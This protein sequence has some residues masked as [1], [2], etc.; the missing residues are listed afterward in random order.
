MIPRS[1]SKHATSTSDSPLSRLKE[2]RQ[3]TEARIGNK[4]GTG[5]TGLGSRSNFSL[6]ERLR[7]TTFDRETPIFQHRRTAASQLREI[8]QIARDGSIITKASQN[9][10]LRQEKIFTK[11]PSV[12]S[13]LSVLNAAKVREN[14]TAKYEASRKENESNIGDAQRKRENDATYAASPMAD[15]LRNQKYDHHAGGQEVSSDERLT[16]A[17]MKLAEAKERLGLKGTQNEEKSSSSEMTSEASILLQKIKEDIKAPLSKPYEGSSSR[18]QG[19]ES[20][21]DKKETEKGEGKMMNAKRV[22]IDNAEIRSSQTDNCKDE[23][24][25]GRIH[26]KPATFTNEIKSSKELDE[27]PLEKEGNSIERSRMIASRIFEKL[28]SKKSVELKTQLGIPK[29]SESAT[30]IS[31]KSSVIS[32]KL[33]DKSEELNEEGIEKREIESDAFELKITK[34]KPICIPKIKSTY[35]AEGT[36]KEVL[37]NKVSIEASDKGEMDAFQVGNRIELVT[38]NPIIGSPASLGISLK[39]SPAISPRPSPPVSP[40]PPKKAPIVLESGD[41]VRVSV[42]IPKD[43]EDKSKDE[44]EER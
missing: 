34:T 4:V 29:K 26:N 21:V 33:E 7:Q 16:T 41:K 40:K 18:M 1:S 27:N 35:K 2:L 19:F 14:A 17:Q 39:P 43:D 12:G 25:N 13:G 32:S 44:T 8:K 36:E 28:E 9:T 22:D 31:Q 10:A 15:R 5:G 3:Q 37:A 11:R 6:T 24:K 20:K 38:E 42:V 30:I 23:D